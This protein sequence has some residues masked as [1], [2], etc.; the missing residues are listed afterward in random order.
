M[1]IKANAVVVCV[2]KLKGLDFVN[3]NVA[4]GRFNIH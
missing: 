4:D 1:T 3:L 2:L